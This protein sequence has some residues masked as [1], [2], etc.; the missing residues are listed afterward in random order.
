[1]KKQKRLYYLLKNKYDISIGLFTGKRFQ[2]EEKIKSAPDG[3]YEIGVVIGTYLPFVFLAGLA[4]LF[5]YF[6]KR[7]FKDKQE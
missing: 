6:A 7:K 3:S 1:M 4:W 2:I 5:Y